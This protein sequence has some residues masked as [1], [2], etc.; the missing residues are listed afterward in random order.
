MRAKESNGSIFAVVGKW[1]FLFAFSPIMTVAQEDSL[2][3]KFTEKKAVNEPFTLYKHDMII[4]S[5]FGHASG[6]FSL[7]YS[8]PYAI[9]K[10]KFRNNYQEVIGVGL[11]YKGFSL[12]LSIA[13]QRSAKSETYYGKTKYFCMGLNF[14][15]KQF[16]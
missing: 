2:P 13:L 4:Y 10:I 8:S 15:Q 5:G 9:E 3:K 7:E 11:C 12:R 1:V 6:P 14:T 16:Y